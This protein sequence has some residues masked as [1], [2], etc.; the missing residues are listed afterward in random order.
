MIDAVLDR[1]GKEIGGSGREDPSSIDETLARLMT[2]RES[3]FAPDY[4]PT[5][6]YKLETN[7]AGDLKLVRAAR[8]IFRRYIPTN[9]LLDDAFFSISRSGARAVLQYD[10]SKELS[11]ALTVKLDDRN[12]LDYI[13]AVE[14]SP[15]FVTGIARDV[16]KHQFGYLPSAISEVI[17]DNTA[18]TL[19]FSSQDDK[20]KITT[21][22]V[23]Y[24][25]GLQTGYRQFEAM[26]DTIRNTTHKMHTQTPIE[27]GVT[28][29]LLARMG[30]VLK[31]FAGDNEQE[32]YEIYTK[33]HERIC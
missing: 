13:V 25:F 33:R 28:R 31:R 7:F 22:R 8:E 30:E 19:V 10:G 24:T 18:L 14:G 16:I 5:H 11:E 9:V 17:C 2:E 4:N 20:M 15:E 21:G 26:L 32:F 29:R 12:D 23:S 27:K 3:S 1:K 6:P